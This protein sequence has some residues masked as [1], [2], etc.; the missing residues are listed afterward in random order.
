MTG[1]TICRSILKLNDNKEKEKPHNNSPQSPL[2]SFTSTIQKRFRSTYPRL[3]CLIPRLILTRPAIN[4]RN[5]GQVRFTRARSS[6]TVS[7]Y[8]VFCAV[9]VGSSLADFMLAGEASGYDVA[10][11]V[12]LKAGEE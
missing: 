9:A 3:P 5:D 11:H 8:F 6:D 7:G 1:L 10:H 12:G 4:L 2:L